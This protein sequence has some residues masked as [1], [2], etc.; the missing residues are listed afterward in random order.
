MFDIKEWRKLQNDITTDSL[1][2]SNTSANNRPLFIIP[3][4]EWDIKNDKVFHGL[5]IPEI[6]YQFIIRFTKMKE[7]IIWDPFYG[8]GTTQRVAKYLGYNNGI[9]SDLNPIDNYCFKKD[10]L[11]YN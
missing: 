1:W 4:R 7:D 3:K 6:P 10:I 8:S 11:D 2:I 5:F 9:Y